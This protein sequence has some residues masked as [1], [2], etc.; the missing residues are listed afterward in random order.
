M[1]N[2]RLIPALRLGKSWRFKREILDEW[3]RRQTR[4][5]DQPPD[6]I[7]LIRHETD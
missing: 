7:T 2:N 4:G 5:G 1:A 6:H 3:I